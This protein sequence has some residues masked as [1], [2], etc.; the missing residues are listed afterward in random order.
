M[1]Y[2]FATS[3]WISESRDKQDR[4]GGDSQSHHTLSFKSGSSETCGWRHGYVVHV[5][6]VFAYNMAGQVHCPNGLSGDAVVIFCLSSYFCEN[7]HQS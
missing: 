6:T 5:Y 1:I 7:N 4:Q 3:F 2:I